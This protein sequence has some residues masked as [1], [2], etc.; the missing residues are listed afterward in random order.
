MLHS[1]GEESQI[2]EGIVDDGI[3]EWKNWDIFKIIGTTIRDVA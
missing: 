1:L 2:G 3:F